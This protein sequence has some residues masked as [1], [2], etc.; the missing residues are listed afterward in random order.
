MPWSHPASRMRE[1]IMALRAIWS[2][3]N[4]GMKLSFRGDFYQH[5]LMTPF[6]SPPPAPGGAPEVFLAAV[7]DAMTPVP[8]EV[9]RGPPV[10]PVCTA[11]RLRREAP[12]AVAPRLAA[13]RPG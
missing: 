1:F 11:R 6:F 10:P 8:G 7:G 3:W 4:D 5:T 12:P 9:A 13:T 2:A